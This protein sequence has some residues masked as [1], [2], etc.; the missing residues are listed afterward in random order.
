MTAQGRPRTTQATKKTRRYTGS[1]L[2]VRRVRRQGLEPRTVALRGH[3]SAN[4]A[5]GAHGEGGYQRRPG[6][7]TASAAPGAGP[8]LAVPAVVDVAAGGGGGGGGGG[9]ASTG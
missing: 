8:G 2:R 3:C 6:A 7:A 5:S 4:G 1:H 9:G